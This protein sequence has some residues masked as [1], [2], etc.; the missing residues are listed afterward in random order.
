MSISFCDS[1][2]VCVVL[3]FQAFLP[4]HTQHTVIGNTSIPSLSLKASDWSRFYFS[5]VRSEN[6]YIFKKTEGNLTVVLFEW[7]EHEHYDQSMKPCVI[8]ETVPR[9]SAHRAGARQDKVHDLIIT[10]QYIIDWGEGLKMTCRFRYLQKKNEDNDETRKFPAGRLFWGTMCVYA[11]W[12]SY[13]LETIT[14]CVLLK[15]LVLSLPSCP[16]QCLQ[17]RETKLGNFRDNRVP[18]CICIKCVFDKS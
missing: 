18:Q 15:V 12:V 17:C 8:F 11:G 14:V 3:S 16:A 6:I 9:H 13:I 1:T 4:E 7:G 10:L 5:R 2:L